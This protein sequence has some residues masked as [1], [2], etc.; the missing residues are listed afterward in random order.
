V[1]DALDPRFGAGD[2]RDRAVADRTLDEI[3]AI[4]FLAAKSAE[5]ITANHLAMIERE[6]GN[7]GIVLDRGE[8]IELH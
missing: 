5:D 7:V 1:R 2:D 4:E 8:V 6:A 3:L